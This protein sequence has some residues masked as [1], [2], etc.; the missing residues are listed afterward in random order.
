MGNKSNKPIE[1]AKIENNFNQTDKSLNSTSNQNVKFTCKYD[2]SKLKNQLNS[3]IN[4]IMNQDSIFDTKKSLKDSVFDMINKKE[5]EELI[6]F[7]TNE[8]NNYINNIS[9]YL[10]NKQILNFNGLVVKLLN[11]EN[12]FDIYKEKVKN[13]IT[14]IKKDE[15]SFEINYL[16]IILI[17]KSGVGK[18]TLINSLLQFKGKKEIE[19]GVGGICT[20]KLITPYQSDKMPFLR[21]VDT[22]GIELN[23]NFGADNITNT[24]ENFIH[25]QKETKDIN[26]FVHCIWYCVTGNR[27]EDVEFDSINRLK[28]AYKRSNIPIVIVFTQTLDKNVSKEMKNY[29]RSKNINDEFVE[30]LAK[31]KEIVNGQCIKPFGLDELLKITINECKKSFSGDMH[32]VMTMNISE[33]IAQQLI[34]EN[35]NIQKYINENNILDFIKG[36]KIKTAQE[37]K[38]YIINIYGKNINYFLNKDLDKNGY[39]LIE[40]SQLINDHLNQFINYYQNEVDKTIS[41]KLSPFAVKGLMI[42][43]DVEIKKG[44]STLIQNKKSY[45]DFFSSNEKFLKDNLYYLAQKNYIGINFSNLFELFSNLFIQNI[46]NNLNQILSLPKIKEKITNLFSKRFSDFEEKIKKKKIPLLSNYNNFDNSSNNGSNNQHNKI[47]NNNIIKTEECKNNNNYNYNEYINNTKSLKKS[48][49]NSSLISSKT[50]SN[51]SSQKKI[52]LQKR[53]NRI[54]RNMS[55]SGK[56]QN[57]ISLSNIQTNKTISYD[58]SNNYMNNLSQNK[59]N[60]IPNPIQN[61]PYKNK[62]IYIPVVPNNYLGQNYYLNRNIPNFPKF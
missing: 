53:V 16:T 14:K 51:Q 59:V 37:F 18:S 50:I 1:E 5:K 34:N 28:N 36:Y 21:L 13:E 45:Q 32:S 23:K 40:K 62:I 38:D 9:Y 7:L 49:S 2:P 8:K 52:F 15:K 17:G 35:S 6:E 46:N 31:E 25:Q 41:D 26:K 42:Q 58:S 10:K 56:S 48:S 3:F 22:R 33:Y 24:C 39:N 44:K 54:K 12:Y 20:T 30:I 47:I 43:A 29:I 4:E 19:H 27:F 55:N 11:E 61:M 57:N 60:Q